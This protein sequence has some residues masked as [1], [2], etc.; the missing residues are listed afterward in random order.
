MIH[1]KILVIPLKLQGLAIVL[2][3]N[4]AGSFFRELDSSTQFGREPLF[5]LVCAIDA[6]DKALW[7][8]ED[9][10]TVASQKEKKTCSGN[11]VQA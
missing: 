1:D 10:R 5:L 9:I 4:I 11:R 8:W 7:L 6:V 3:N 2:A